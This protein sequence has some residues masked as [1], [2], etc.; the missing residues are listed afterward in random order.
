MEFFDGKEEIIDIQLTQFGKHQLSKGK[1]QPKFYCFFDDD[2]IYDE[3]H[4][5]LETDQNKIEDRILNDPRLK[6]QT[7]IGTVDN[8][9]N[10]LS[11]KD[12]QNLI[13]SIGTSEDSNR[14]PSWEVKFFKEN[15]I[16]VQVNATGSYFSYNPVP[17]LNCEI[18]FVSEIKNG[19]EELSYF[20]D[21]TYFDIIEDDLF[22]RIE[23]HG[24][25]LQ[26]ENFELE[27]FEIETGGSDGDVLNQIELK[28]SD[29]FFE[30]LTD[31]EISDEDF[32]IVPY[33]ERTLYY[34]DRIRNN[35]KSFNNKKVENIYPEKE[36][37]GDC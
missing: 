13:S 18:E 30:I 17:Q 1:L 36:T 26:K 25:K 34:I 4:G 28:D 37:K 19:S 15:L 29:Y 32:C 10:G 20:Q 12:E 24:S 27:I 11:Y 31:N 7:N 8:I 9:D 33:K 16:S 6:L 23:E 2:I 14:Y 3:A 22:L 21:G 5:G 35:K